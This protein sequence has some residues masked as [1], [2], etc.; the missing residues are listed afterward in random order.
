MFVAVCETYHLRQNYDLIV[1]FICKLSMM[2][3]K[4]GE[5]DL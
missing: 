1:V 2:C 4:L 5:M 3:V